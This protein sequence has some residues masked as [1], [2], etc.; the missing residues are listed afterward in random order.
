[1]PPW[2]AGGLMSAELRPRYRGIELADS[3]V[4]DLHKWFFQSLGG[5]LLLYRDASWARQLFFETS[6]YLPSAE[7]PTPEQH[8][9]FHIA[10]ELSRRFRALPFYIAMRCY[11]IDRLGRNALHNVQC[12]EYLADLVR[13]QE[14]LELIVAPQL[15]ILCF[16]FKPADFDDTEIDRIN[17]E[18]R[19]RIQLEGDYLM[20]A[21]RVHDRP[22]LRVCI[23]NHAIRA[24][25]I[26]GL[27][28]SVLR[29]GR[30]LLRP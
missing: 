22:V 23:I 17:S 13:Q 9:F 25:H 19:D 2:A 3:V 14:E 12:T 6:D 26:E 28:A 5:S 21:T 15:C 27:L 18:I 16:R 24:E 20:S 10:P 8:M 1:M 30:S 29:I 7:E 11:G 4:M